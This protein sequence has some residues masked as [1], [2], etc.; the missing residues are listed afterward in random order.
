ML[1]TKIVVIGAG[2]ASFGLS[3]LTSLMRSN[4]LHGSRLALVDKNSEALSLVGRLAERLNREWG[5]GVSITLHKHHHKALEGAEFVVVSIE[6]PPREE[7][8]KMDYE[9]PLKYGVRQPY[10]ENGGPGG[11]AH[12]ARNI[13]SI[14]EIAHD[15]QKS[16][17][18]AWMLNFSNPLTRL[19]DAVNRY[20]QIIVV[21]LCHQIYMGYAIVGQLLHNDLGIEIEVEFTNTAATPNQFL[22]RKEVVRQAIDK[23]KIV[24]AGINHFTWILSVHDRHTG[25]DLYPKFRERWDAYNQDF[26]PLTRRIFNYFDMFPVAG[27]E[28]ISEYLPWVSD[29]I[30][31]PWEKYNISLYEWDLMQKRRS[32]GYEDIAKMGAGKQDIEELKDEESEGAVELIEALAGG[33]NHYHLAVNL[34]NQGYILNLPKDAIVEVPGIADGS[35][36]KGLGVGELPNGIT[37]LCRR[38]LTTGQL[39]VDAVLQGDRKLAMQSLLLDPVIRDIEVAE[40]ILEDYLL[41]YRDHLPQFWT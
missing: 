2:S 23:I 34:P 31:K 40:K 32:D 6:T 29:P 30:T 27:D 25:E 22:L 4:K 17:P 9:I 38:E 16:C 21:G 12:A 14:I 11:F 36:V 39:C 3:T 13:G 26:E 18:N 15:M 33:G 8:W 10:A 19:C 35:G 28:H 37:E 7:L 5:S 24:A 20:S 1:P 41:T